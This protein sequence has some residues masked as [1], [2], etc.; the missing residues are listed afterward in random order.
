MTEF[1]PPSLAYV[2]TL[3]PNLTFNINVMKNAIGTSI[4]SAKS[5]L[6]RV[7]R[8]HIQQLNIPQNNENLDPEEGDEENENNIQDMDAASHTTDASSE[9]DSDEDKEDYVKKK[10]NEDENE[11]EETDGIDDMM[12]DEEAEEED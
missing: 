9:D 6:R 4:R 7:E 2:R 11:D 12:I 3:H 5:E 10:V 1:L 8:H